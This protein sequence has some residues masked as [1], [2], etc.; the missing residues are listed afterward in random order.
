MARSSL[1]RLGLSLLAL[2]AASAPGAAQ[3][4]GAAGAVNP[5]ATGTPPAR[6]A[7]VLEL[8][9]RV[10][11]KERIQTTANGSVQLI[12][13]DKSTL[14]VGPNSDL[15]IDEF[16]Y[17]PNRG[18]GQMAVSMTKGLLRF[19]GGNISHSGGATV[20]TPV[21]TLGIRGGVATIKH[22]PC[23]PRFALGDE[24]SRPPGFECGTRAINHFG[25]LSVTSAAGSE[26]IRRPG[27]AV[28]IV[29]GATAL[30]PPQR[31]SQAE[32]DATNRQLSSKPGQKG[33]VRAQPTDQTAARAGVGVENAAVTPSLVSV[34]QTAASASASPAT[35]L[36][37]VLQGAQSLQQQAAAS[38]T[39]AEIQ[40][41]VQPA[42]PLQARAFALTTSPDPALNSPV[43]YVL[44]SAVTTG[45]VFISPIVGYRNA[46]TSEQPDPPARTLQVAIGVEGDGSAQRS[47]LMVSTG[48]FFSDPN[49]RPVFSG[50]FGATSQTGSG[51]LPTVA[52]GSIA[53]LPDTVTRDAERL[54]TAARVNQNRFDQNGAVVSQTAQVL[55]PDGAVTNYNFQQDFA[56]T[57]TPDALGSNRPGGTLNGFVGGIVTTRDPDGAVIPPAPLAGAATLQFDPGDSR[58]QMN[59]TVEAV[60]DGP[61][62]AGAYTSATYQFGSLDPAQPAQSAYI[63]RENFGARQAAPTGSP[64]APLTTVNG[65]PVSSDMLIMANANRAAA[66][67][68]PDVTFCDCEFTRWGVWSAQS[69]QSGFSDR[70]HIGTWVV[71]QVPPNVEVPTVGTASYRGHVVASIANNG[72]QYLAAGDL[73]STINFGTRS[74]SASVTNFDGRNYSGPLTL[75]AGSPGLAGTLTTSDPRISMGMAGSLFRG[76]SGPVGEMGGSVLINGSAL[77]ITGSGIFAGK[78]VGGIAP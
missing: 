74:G 50:G 33:G 11:H 44:G 76:V 10:I 55:A 71:G 28:T 21:A 35:V 15:V 24:R 41:T 68:R 8:G 49:G 3:E 52:S 9:A 39:Q 45:Q 51:G 17:D 59:M 6:A 34:Q 12:F 25:I 57:A 77:G 48:V 31:V 5:A 58:V 37:Q 64:S 78:M 73:A 16:V 38:T 26:I 66:G 40:Q 63:D 72:S 27:F 32:I 36:T 54:P 1:L 60:R 69:E 30:P 53:S 43:P 23:D 70:V 46:G 62:P 22:V 67:V 13:L 4:V 19:V 2:A 47:T 56:R 65:N 75:G 20:K 29:P 14:S 18:A 42:G 7:R 61:V